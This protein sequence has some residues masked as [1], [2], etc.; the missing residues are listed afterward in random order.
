MI[1]ENYAFAHNVERTLSEDEDKH[2]HP[3]RPTD[4]GNTPRTDLHR[5][6]PSAEAAVCCM[7]NT[8]RDDA[9]PQDG[10]HQWITTKGLGRTE[11]TLTTKITYLLFCKFFKELIKKKIL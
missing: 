2:P 1:L 4:P 7:R 5:L 11:A 9:T 8:G 10:K 3:H 6:L